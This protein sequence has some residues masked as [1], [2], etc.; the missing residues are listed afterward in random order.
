MF[1]AKCEEYGAVWT[2]PDFFQDTFGEHCVNLT[3]HVFLRGVLLF[4]KLREIDT[5]FMRNAS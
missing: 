3:I 1:I 4:M 2:V 5:V